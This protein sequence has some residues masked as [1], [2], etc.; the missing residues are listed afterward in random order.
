MTKSE[1][2]L[3]VEYRNLADSFWRNEE[4]GERR[5]NLFITLVTAVISALVA[6]ATR[7]A[8]TNFDDAIM[9]LAL[10]ALLAL[11]SVTFLRMLRRNQVTDEYKRAMDAIRA[12]FKEGDERLRD[13]EPFKRTGRKVGRGGL[14]EMV[15]VLNGVIA[16]AIGMVG[17]V[18]LSLAWWV[19]GLLGIG[20]FVCALVMQ[21]KVISRAH[22]Q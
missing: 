22:A 1:D 7:G 15:A 11:G 9:L 16:G 3:L 21:F 14:A 13:Y 18:I 6:L 5:V 20:C 8:R 19:A 2:F 10:L 4:A 12:F 17:G